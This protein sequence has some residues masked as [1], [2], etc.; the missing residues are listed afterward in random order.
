MGCR[1]LPG[2]DEAPSEILH[3]SREA[4]METRAKYQKDVQDSD[5]YRGKKIDG[6]IKRVSPLPELRS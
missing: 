4:E 6:K 3:C 5:G 1:P 2:N